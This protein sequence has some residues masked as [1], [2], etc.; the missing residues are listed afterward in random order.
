[1]LPAAVAVRACVCVVL[2]L[3]TVSAFAQGGPPLVTDDPD[4]PGDGHWEINLAAVLSRARASDTLALPDADINYG[5]GPNVQLKLELPWVIE[6]DDGQATQSGIGAANLGV[7]WRFVDED[8]A[9]VS[10]STYPQ[11]ASGLSTSSVRRGLAPGSH[12]IFLPVEVAS[13]LGDFGVD[14]EVGRA[15]VEGGPDEW[16]GGVVGSHS[17]GPTVECLAELHGTFVA[18]G[19]QTL[20]NVGMRWR[21]SEAWTILASAGREFG[22]KTG[23][24]QQLLMYLGIQIT[25]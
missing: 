5:W 21:M 17:C 9:G 25:R 11:Y 16:L 10:V 4:T 22:Q 20:L 2:F 12:Q 13:K 7:K 19:N 23:S 1:V 6:H 3:S 14:A 18:H 24:Q 15:L 8:D